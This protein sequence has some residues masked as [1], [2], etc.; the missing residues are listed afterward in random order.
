MATIKNMPIAAK[1]SFATTSII[2]AALLYSLFPMPCS[3]AIKCAADTGAIPPVS[4]C[5]QAGTVE[6][7]ANTMIAKNKITS[8]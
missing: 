1:A 2:G 3:D 7:D 8:F 5:A 6:I 4:A